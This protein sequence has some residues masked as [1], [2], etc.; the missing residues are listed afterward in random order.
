MYAIQLDQFEGPLDL[1]LF[2]IRKEEVDIY[3]IPIA[4]IADEYLEVVRLMEEVDLDGVGDF[5]YLAAVL[6]QIKAR[7]LLPSQEVDEEG[8]PI[9]PRKELIDRLLEYV[10]YKEAGYLLNQAREQR[11]QHYTG[12]AVVEDVV[13]DIDEAQFED[14]TVY[15]LMVALADVLKRAPVDV[16]Y[17][18]RNEEYSVESQAQFLLEAVQGDARVSFRQ[19]MVNRVKA[20]VI[21]TFLAVLEMARRGEVAVMI[22]ASATDFYLRIPQVTE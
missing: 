8:E 10:R 15:A 16:V 14:A 19:L 21:A 5:I 2:F 3:D 18:V 9:D 20:F 6:I 1:L 7:M 11:S 4:Q 13:E 17:E 22:S 12:G